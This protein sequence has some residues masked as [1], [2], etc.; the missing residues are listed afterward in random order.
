M[1]LFIEN[2]MFKMESVCAIQSLI[3]LKINVNFVS[4]VLTFVK[5]VLM[6]IIASLATLMEISTQL[7]MMRVNVFVMMDGICKKK[8]VKTVQLPLPDVSTVMMPKHVH[9]VMPKINSNQME[10][11]DVNVWKVTGS[12]QLL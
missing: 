10:K 8:S 7:L 11:E 3:H 5:V 2:K 12:I 4:K 1:L 6:P 9:N